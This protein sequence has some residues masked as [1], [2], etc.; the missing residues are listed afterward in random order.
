V[1]LKLHE[2]DY[3]DCKDCRYME[4]GAKRCE[5]DCGQC[6]GCELLAEQDKDQEFKEKMAMGYL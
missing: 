5:Y 4:A 3:C 2:P 6:R 1:N